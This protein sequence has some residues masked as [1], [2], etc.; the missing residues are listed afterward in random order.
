MPVFLTRRI[1]ARVFC[2]ILLLHLDKKPSQF[3]ELGRPKERRMQNAFCQMCEDRRSELQKWAII[4]YCFRSRQS[5]VKTP[6]HAKVTKNVKKEYV[7]I[8][9]NVH[10]MQ[11]DA[12]RHSFCHKWQRSLGP[13]PQTRQNA[14]CTYPESLVFMLK[15]QQHLCG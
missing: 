9:V 4:L 2:E 8:S 7:C 1:H 11:F 15:K 6:T 3:D 10:G 12:V 13:N 5:L 14:V